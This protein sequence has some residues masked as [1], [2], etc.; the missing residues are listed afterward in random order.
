MTNNKDRAI[1]K[2]KEELKT[3]ILDKIDEMINDV[4]D[5]GYFNALQDLKKEIKEIFD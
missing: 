3:Q 1:A 4:E 2:V 5:S